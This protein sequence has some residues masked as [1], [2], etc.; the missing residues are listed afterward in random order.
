MFFYIQYS[1]SL[2]NFI[3][4]IFRTSELSFFPYTVGSWQAERFTMDVLQ[5]NQFTITE[6]V[7]TLHLDIL[8]TRFSITFD[9]YTF[10]SMDV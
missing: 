2:L 8:W 6:Q 4:P 1:W 10:D 3:S 5:L 7:K 9:V